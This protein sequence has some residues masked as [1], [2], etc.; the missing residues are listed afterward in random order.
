[1]K[2]AALFLAML[3][4]ASAFVSHQPLR[5]MTAPRTRAAPVSMSVFTN[6]ME[7]FK[8]EYP[9]FAAKGWG[10]SAKAE[11]W[12]GRHAM[13]GWF[14][15]ICTGY[16]QAHGLIPNADQP[17]DL[18]EWGTLATISGKST[19]TNERAVILIANVHAFMVGICATVAPLGYMDKL[20]LD[21]GEV[22][23]EPAGVFPRF[24][25]GLT[26]D[27]ELMNGRMAMMGLITATGYSLISG[28]SF[29][30][31]VN[32]WLGGLLIPAN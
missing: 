2:V 20:L 23:E 13:F 31:V 24:S 10:P 28:M 8:N 3:A 4:G 7:K 22:D 25:T 19:I 14:F 16:A 32:Y 27:A 5:A 17:L 12:N 15:I 9:E 1:M 30:E 18:K 21:D 29:M 26:K 11:R 6:A